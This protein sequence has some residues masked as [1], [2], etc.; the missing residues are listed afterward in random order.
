VLVRTLAAAVT[1]PL[2]LLSACSEDDPEPIVA[3]SPTASPA[4]TEPSPTK[5]AEREDPKEFIQRWWDLNTDL[6]NTGDSKAFQSVSA[7]SCSPCNDFIALIEGFYSAGGYVE[8]TKFTVTTVRPLNPGAKK[9]AEFI[10]KGTGGRT[11]YRESKSAP[12]ET[13]PGGDSEYR[14]VLSLGP[15]GWRVT[16]YLQ[17]S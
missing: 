13:L 4:S 3:P 6:Q 12:V 9:K 11:T 2:L 10:V 7:K 5:S 16:D 1:V 17:R 15:T 8:T 14:F